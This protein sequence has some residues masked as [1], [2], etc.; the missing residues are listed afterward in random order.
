MSKLRLYIQQF[1]IITKT[2]QENIKRLLQLMIHL[3]GCNNL[4]KQNSNALLQLWV[5]SQKAIYYLFL[6]SLTLGLL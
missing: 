5:F 3:Q 1:K 4:L 6:S 2:K